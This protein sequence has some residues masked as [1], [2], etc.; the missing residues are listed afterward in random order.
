MLVAF[1]EQTE[2]LSK[3]F[4]CYAIEEKVDGVVDVEDLVDYRLSQIVRF[5]VLAIPVGLS[6]EHDH[7]GRIAYHEANRSCE[8]K[9][10]HLQN[11]SILGIGRDLVPVEPE[12]KEGT[13]DENIADQDD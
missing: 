4:A 3:A 5:V 10:R 9:N 13:N 6:N 7:A 8:T 1:A 12:N 2:R 11:V